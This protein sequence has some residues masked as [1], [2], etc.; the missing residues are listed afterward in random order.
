MSFGFGVGD[1]LAV[2]KL[3][4]HLWRSFKDAPQEFAEI[5]RELSSINIVIAD[6]SDQTGTPT[7]L[8][9]RRGASRK[10]E[11]LTLCENLTSTLE[12]LQETYRKF[13]NMG[14]N[15]WMRAR[16]GERDLQSLRSKLSLHIGLLETFVSS[17]TLASVGRMEP[18]M[19]EVLRIVQGMARGHGAGANS[20][21]QASDERVDGWDTLEREF[22][23]GGVPIDF[24]QSHANDIMTLVN[25]VIDEEMLGDAAEIQPCDS[26]SQ[27]GVQS[28]I[29]G[30]YGRPHFGPN[31]SH[32]SLQTPSPVLSSNQ[33]L[34]NM[35]KE[36]PGD[37]ILAKIRE[38]TTLMLNHGYDLEKIQQPRKQPALPPPL[39]PVK[40]QTKPPKPSIF[41]SSKRAF[42]KSLAAEQSQALE[43]EANVMLI[44]TTKRG[45]IMQ[46]SKPRSIS[47]TSMA[48]ERFATKLITATLLE[49]S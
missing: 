37:E 5:R 28:S 45:M 18:M 26:A 14:R 11:L 29:S 39:R 16:L 4:L 19:V 25:E 35:L 22:Q 42:A 3:S 46:N 33:V 17:L 38:A 48:R 21:V 2:G 1:F 32:R 15:A 44:G 30:V 31:L 8:L 49:S 41:P 6:V 40:L 36:I 10:E 13:R 23:S 12:E 20:L 34:E 27:V 47:E 9:N 24:V 7:S 43:R